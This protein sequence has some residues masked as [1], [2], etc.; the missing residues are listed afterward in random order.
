MQNMIFILLI[1]I[2]SFLYIFVIPAD[3]EIIHIL[4][5]VIPMLLIILYGWK[6]MPDKK[7]VT[8]YF[9]ICGLIFSTVG[10]ATLRWFVV[11]L[12]AFLIGHLFY[13][14]AFRRV[15]IFSV[16]K[17]LS[18]IILVPFALWMGKHLVSSLNQDGE[19]ALVLPVLA[20]IIVIM[21]MWF[22]AIL[23]SNAFAIIGSI[24]FVISD[25]ILAWNMFVSPIEQAGILIMLT[26]Y[27]AQLFIASS[28]FKI[29]KKKFIF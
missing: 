14:A 29:E 22:L 21:L 3:P 9:I 23:T 7:T 6:N 4:F 8:H 26:Y 5:K 19:K 20:Y 13:I 24:L 10:D 11:G 17:L 28:I 1:V 18:L 16:S 2:F 27:G 12:S 25:S 15:I